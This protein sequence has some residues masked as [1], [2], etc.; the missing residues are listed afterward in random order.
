[1][2][3][4]NENVNPEIAMAKGI[5]GE[6]DEASESRS[7]AMLDSG[8]N[9]VSGASP[10]YPEASDNSSSETEPV[11]PTENSDS[12]ND[13][14]GAK[15]SPTEN[16]NSAKHNNDEEL[17]DLFIAN[18]EVEE[19]AYF[20]LSINLKE[21]KIEFNKANRVPAYVRDYY[22]SLNKDIAANNKKQNAYADKNP[23]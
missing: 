10:S 1:M 4:K 17:V 15:P 2:S 6:A 23:A 11:S 5:S 12:D 9:A 16:A 21:F 3:K 18:A 8:D 13:K 20:T 7:N 19:G 14:A 22:Y